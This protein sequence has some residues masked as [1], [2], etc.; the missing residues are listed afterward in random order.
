LEQAKKG[1]YKSLEIEPG[2]IE[3][4]YDLAYVL[5]QQGKIKEA[6]ENYRQT[7][8]LQPDNIQILTHIAWI[9]ATNENDVIR[10]GEQAIQLAE[11]AN[12]LSNNNQAI[13]LDTLAAAYAEAGRFERAVKTA[14]KAFRLAKL[15]KRN[16]LMND[17]R[18]RIELYNKQ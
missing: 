7:L 12:Q 6:L 10:N 3:A 9:L 8:G 13:V 18:E 5:E 14:E 4:R 11:K 16:D 15:N 1:Y 2:F 17:I